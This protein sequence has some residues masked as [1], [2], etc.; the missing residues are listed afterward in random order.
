MTWTSWQFRMKCRYSVQRNGGYKLSPPG[1]SGGRVPA[2]LCVIASRF[3]TSWRVSLPTQLA[4]VI[5]RLHLLIWVLRFRYIWENTGS[6][7]KA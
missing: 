1:V 7:G 6:S 2:W 3:A 5:L 4:G